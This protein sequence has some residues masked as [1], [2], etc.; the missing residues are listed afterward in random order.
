[1]AN[2]LISLSVDITVELA[3]TCLIS[4]VVALFAI[5]GLVVAG[6]DSP[7][8]D[9][10]KEFGKRCK[11]FLEFNCPMV[12]HCYTVGL[13]LSLVIDYFTVFFFFWYNKTETTFRFQFYYS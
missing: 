8:P 11:L 1:M 9:P 2:A 5:S 12:F 13:K 3:E 7:K 4:L 10:Q 6:I